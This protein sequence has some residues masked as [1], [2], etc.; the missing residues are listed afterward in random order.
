MPRAPNAAPA[1]PGE[2]ELVLPCPGLVCGLSRRLLPWLLRLGDLISSAGME[3]ERERRRSRGR[4]LAAA[5]AARRADDRDGGRSSGGS[6]SPAGR[7][8]CSRGVAKD[9]SIYLPPVLS[10]SRMFTSTQAGS[11]SRFL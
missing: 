10:F 5:L 1:L 3:E 11:I 6:G 2:V 9:F 4:R 8:G 7:W